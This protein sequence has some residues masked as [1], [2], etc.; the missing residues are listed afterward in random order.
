M[1][2]KDFKTLCDNWMNPEDEFLRPPRC[3]LQDSDNIIDWCVEEWNLFCWLYE[4]DLFE[5]AYNYV[6]QNNEW[7]YYS[8]RSDNWE[9]IHCNF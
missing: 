4:N 7:K 5:I 8:F 6:T 1:S 2:A 3:D 9:I